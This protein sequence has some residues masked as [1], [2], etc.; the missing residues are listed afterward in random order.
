MARIELRDATIRIKDGFGG[1]AAIDQ[2]VDISATSLLRVIRVAKPA[3]RPWSS[4]MAMSFQAA[5]R[6]FPAYGLMGVAKSALESVVRYLALELGRNRIR[7]NAISPGP[8]ETLSSYGEVL[9]ISSDAEAVKRFRGDL[10]EASIRHADEQVT[11]RAETRSLEWLQAVES[12]VK[13]T[14]AARSAIE[15]PVCKEDVAGCAL[16][17][18]SRLSSKIT[19]QVIHVDAGL[20]SCLIV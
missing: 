6:A 1:T 7:V 9:A 20:S 15:E 4:V 17:L 16:F 11:G 2:T 19:G 14:I 12:H 3:L 13:R 8:I 5:N 10:V 18:G